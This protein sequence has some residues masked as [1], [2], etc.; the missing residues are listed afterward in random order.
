MESHV[1]ERASA[2]S[3]SGTTRVRQRMQLALRVLVRLHTCR[4]LMLRH[5]RRSIEPWRLRLP[6]FDV[7][8]ELARAPRRGF[9]FVELSQ[10]LL[11]TSAN[12]T[13]IV[14]RLEAEGLAR[15]RTDV[16]DRR[17]IR[18]KLTVRG[19]ELL[20]ALLPRHAADV[21]EL[22]SAMAPEKLEALS[23]LLNELQ[24][25]LRQRD[26]PPPVP[27]TGDSARGRSPRANGVASASSRPGACASTGAAVRSAGPAA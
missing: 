9:T 22:L 1:V 26:V 20:N 11:V 18:L 21:H 6:Q 2:S 15:R 8:A 14:D 4:N 16:L 10:F 17:V 23:A 7:L 19:R 13:G 5:T 25:M 24:H 3:G 12:L 27:R